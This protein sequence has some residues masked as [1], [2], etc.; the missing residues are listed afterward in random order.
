MRHGCNKPD[1][2]VRTR[3]QNENPNNPHI[4]KNQNN[5][6]PRKTRS[7]FTPLLAHTGPNVMYRIARGPPVAV[8]LTY[9]LTAVER[10]TRRVPTVFGRVV[11]L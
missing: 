2:D 6:I 1:S 5:E 10:L 3:E 4:H 11:F 7:L 8:P 9:V